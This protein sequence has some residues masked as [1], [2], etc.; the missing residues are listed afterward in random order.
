MASGRMWPSPL[1]DIGEVLVQE[2]R[3]SVMKKTRLSV[4]YPVENGKVMELLI[5]Q[6]F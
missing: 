1:R 2:E 6:A 3:F 5:K 4:Q